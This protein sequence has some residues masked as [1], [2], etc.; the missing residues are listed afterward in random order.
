MTAGDGSEH[1]R[2]DPCAAAFGRRHADRRPDLDAALAGLYGN[3]HGPAV[4]AAIVERARVAAKRRSGALRKLDVE[5]ERDD[6]WYQSTAVV[7]Y[8]A[9]ADR[10]GGDLAGIRDRIGYL[11]ELG[12]TLLHL[13]SVL[14]ARPGA[15]D[16]GYAV[17][18]YR[19]PDPALGTPADLAALAG[20][21]RSSGIS[22]CLDFVMNH[23]SDTHHW[24]RAARRG[25]P[26]ARAM[27]LTFPDRTE[28]DRYEAFLPEVFPDAAPGNFTF[29]ADLDAWVWTTFHGYQ[30]DLNYANPAVLVAMVDE[31]LH[32]ANLGVDVVRLDAVAFTGKRHGTNCQNQPEAH[33]VAQALRAAVGMAAP[34]TVLLA[35]AIVGPDDLV[36]YLG[37]HGVE[38]GEGERRE[39][40]LAYHNQLMVLGWSMLAEQNAALATAALTR[41]PDA[42]ESAQWLTYVR[43]HDDIGWAV[44]DADAAAVGVTGHGHRE[45]LASFY[46]GR[47]SGSFADGEPFSTNPRVGDERT[48]GGTASLTGLSRAVAAGDGTAVDLAVRRILFLYSISF[49]WGGIPLIYMG[50]E[51]GLAD[52]LAYRGDPQRAGDS[53]WRHRPTMDWVLADRRK[54]AGTIERRLFTAMQNLVAARLACP[55]LQGGATTQAIGPFHPQAFSWVRRHKRWGTVIGVAN[56][57]STPVDVRIEARHQLTGTVYDG[58][59]G[60]PVDVA[61]PVALGPYQVRW[62]TGPPRLATVPAVVAKPFS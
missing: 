16:G 20:A 44:S 38:D 10:F 43:C 61:A 48:S 6:R 49:G 26:R 37:R 54:Q 50:D 35:E 40:E 29:D 13:M 62:I 53:R 47:F 60:E 4:A 3:E 41:L 1:R 8:Q 39:C 14:R 56:T 52:D 2:A 17:E 57:S 42:P 22:L 24:A 51:I 19:S 23:T 7:G 30:W 21:L 58:L 15:N 59:S 28:P 31:L 36:P 55:P 25:D 32:L 34:A 9:Y 33:L 12:V 27:Y 11:E 46:G 45:F 5:R 18:D